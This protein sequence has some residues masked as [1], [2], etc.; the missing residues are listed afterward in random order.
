[1]LSVFKPDWKVSCEYLALELLKFLPWMNVLYPMGAVSEMGTQ[2]PWPAV[3]WSKNTQP[4][5][6][7]PCNCIFWLL[8]I[9]ISREQI[10]SLDMSVKGSLYIVQI[11][12]VLQVRLSSVLQL[13][14]L[15]WV[16]RFW[17]VQSLIYCLDFTMSVKA[18][19]SP[20]PEDL[21]SCWK[22]LSMIFKKE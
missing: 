5:C 19:C 1:M 2:F 10:E 11:K 21:K 6:D 20:I 18:D 17:V 12:S 13:S 7:F 8:I 4:Q 3:A 22:A 15:L 16:H 9:R 14:G